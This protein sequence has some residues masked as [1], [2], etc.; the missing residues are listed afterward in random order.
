MYFIAC[1]VSDLIFALPDSFGGEIKFFN[2]LQ[3]GVDQSVKH[4]FLDENRIPERQIGL[5]RDDAVDV[6]C[7]TIVTVAYYRVGTSLN[8]TL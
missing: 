8:Q 6:V 2:N 4:V 1:W 5:G 7:G 3:S